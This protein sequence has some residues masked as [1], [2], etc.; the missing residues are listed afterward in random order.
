MA[1]APPT[2][3]SLLLRIRDAGDHR[4][5]TQFASVYA[6]LVYG[7]ARK[8]GLQDHDAADLTQEVLA[9]VARA[10]RGLEYD[11]R[12]GTFRGWLF[13]IVQRE[14]IDFLTARRRS[15]RGTGD[16]GVHECLCQQPAPD[17]GVEAAWEHEYEQ[18][19]F[20]WA[21]DQVRPRVE[22]HTWAAFWR[23]AVGSEETRAVAADLNITVAAVRLAKSRVMAQIRKVIA[24][25]QLEPGGGT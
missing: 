10:V 15:P 22:P 13:T 7:H 3:P 4:A 24:Q 20:A 25:L 19:L 17:D 23:T 6:P 8:R 21:G 18:R 9:R 2:R 12:R 14:L 1:D 5:W 16:T 11:P